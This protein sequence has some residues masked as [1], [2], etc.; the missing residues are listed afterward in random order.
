M[1]EETIKRMTAIANEIK[2]LAVEIMK[3]CGSKYV[4]VQD[5]NGEIVLRYYLDL[6]EKTA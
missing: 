3:E 5:I 4:S 1:S 6:Q 2:K